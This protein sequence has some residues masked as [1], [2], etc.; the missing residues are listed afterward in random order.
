MHCDAKKWKIKGFNGLS[1]I[2]SIMKKVGRFRA[3]RNV[4]SGWVTH[5]N[6]AR[7]CTERMFHYVVEALLVLAAGAGVFCFGYGWH[8]FAVMFVLVHTGWWVVN[9]NFHVYMLDSFRFVRNA[10]VDKEL[11]YIVWAGGHFKML[12]AKAVLVYG[13]F[14]RKEFH[15]RSDLDLRIIRDPS[16]NSLS[17]LIFGVYARIVSMLYGCPT[18]LQ[19][20]DSEAFLLKQ[21]SIKEI[22]V[23]VFGGEN[24]TKIK[25]SMSISDVCANPSIVMKPEREFEGWI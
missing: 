15:G 11:K 12:G 8:A 2:G 4:F 9:G 6:H 13:S 1:G 5:A 7:D 20:V 24:L 25:C 22:P 18:D 10:G 23:D 3:I 17:L 16:R 21:M 14:C 19:I